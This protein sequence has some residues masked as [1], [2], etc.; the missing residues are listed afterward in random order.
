MISRSLVVPGVHFVLAHPLGP[1][2]VR[3][4]ASGRDARPGDDQDAL[5]CSQESDEPFAR[6]GFAVHGPIVRSVG[7][8]ASRDKMAPEVGLEPTTTRLTAACSTIELLWNP[9]GPKL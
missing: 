6:A 2:K 3:D 5:G 7:G 9:K 1:A 8:G 4:A